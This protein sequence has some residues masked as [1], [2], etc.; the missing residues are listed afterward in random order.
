M[1]ASASASPSATPR[2][3]FETTDQT[4]DA[5]VLASPLPTLVDFTAPWCAPCRAIAPHLESVAAQYAGAARIASCDVDQ[6]VLIA[7][8]YG[9][10]AMPTLLMFKDGRV[11]GQIVGAVPRSKIEALIAKALD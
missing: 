9:V 4:F 3:V 10:R 5:E 11:V 7:T 1:S 8:R 6:N 2:L